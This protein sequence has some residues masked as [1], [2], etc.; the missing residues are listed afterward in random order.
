MTEG[1]SGST[2][3][4]PVELDPDLRAKLRAAGDADRV[5]REISDIERRVG[6]KF[7]TLG[8]DFDR[9]LDVLRTYGYVDVDAWE[10]TEAGEMLAQNVPR[11]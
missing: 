6:G 7:R 4:H 3:V 2:D 1:P 8:Q 11:V 10:L 9:V 5:A